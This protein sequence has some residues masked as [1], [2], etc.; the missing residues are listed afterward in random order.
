ML[1]YGALGK[2]YEERVITIVN[3]SLKIHK[4]LLSVTG[5]NV[6]QLHG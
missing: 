6:I 3:T 2:E 1:N 4:H 5:D